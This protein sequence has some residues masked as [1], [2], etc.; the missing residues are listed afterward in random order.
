MRRIS[1]LLNLF[2]S[3]PPFVV[4]DLAARPLD[5]PLS[6]DDTMINKMTNDQ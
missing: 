2:L 1:T 4:L 5:P 6:F 3:L